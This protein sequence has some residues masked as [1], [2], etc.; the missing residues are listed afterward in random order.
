M[1]EQ[2][3][4]QPNPSASAECDHALTFQ[5]PGHHLTSASAASQTARLAL[6]QASSTG[7]RLATHAG[8]ESLTLQAR[9][10]YVSCWSRLV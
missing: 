6:V 5:L 1:A 3:G 9:V 10:K 4:C 8:Y 7:M 2:S